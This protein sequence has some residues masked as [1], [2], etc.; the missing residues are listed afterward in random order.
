MGCGTDAVIAFKICEII[1]LN[2]VKFINFIQFI[3]VNYMCGGTDAY[4]MVL[5]SANN[6]ISCCLGAQCVFKNSPHLSFLCLFL[7]Y[8]Y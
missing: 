3:V 5:D 4:S 6:V 2:V 1:S 8:Y 7:L